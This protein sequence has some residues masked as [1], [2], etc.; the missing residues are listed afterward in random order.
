MTDPI[1]AV[2]AVIKRGTAILMVKRSKPPGEGLWSLPGGKVEAG[3]SPPEALR[4]EIAEECNI[5]VEVGQLVGWVERRDPGH[6]FVILDYEA[7]R[8]DSFLEPSPGDDA[9]EAVFVERADLGALSLVDG[10]AHFLSS[11]HLA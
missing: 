5:E 7:R 2:G 6:H 11:H 8:L 3:E 1:L 10:L 4:R 9:A